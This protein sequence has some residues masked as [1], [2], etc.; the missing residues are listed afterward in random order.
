M[1]GWRDGSAEKSTSFSFSRLEFNFQHIRQAVPKPNQTKPVTPAPL[2]AILCSGYM[3]VA[4]LPETHIH[5]N[6]M[7]F[8]KQWVTL[9]WTFSHRKQDFCPSVTHGGLGL[10]QIIYDIPNSSSPEVAGKEVAGWGPDEVM[11]WWTPVGKSCVEAPIPSPPEY[12]LIRIASSICLQERVRVWIRVSVSST[13]WPELMILPVFLRL[14]IANMGHH[15]PQ[16][17]FKKR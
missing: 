2:D 3:C 17:S 1:V 6:K 10:L 15:F 9:P 5:I 16:H 4:A 14:H 12:S 13:S 11:G 8:Q 7:N